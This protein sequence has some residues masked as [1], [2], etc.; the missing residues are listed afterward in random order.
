MEIQVQC[1]ITLEVY[2]N[3]VTATSSLRSLYSGG[4]KS[5]VS[6]LKILFNMATPLKNSGNFFVALGDLINDG[7]GELCAVFGYY[8]HFNFNKV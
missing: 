1:I 5:S 4:N 8:S 3:P 7:G 2:S 6:D